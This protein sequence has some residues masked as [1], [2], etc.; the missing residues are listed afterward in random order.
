MEQANDKQDS[1]KYSHDKISPEKRR[2][3]GPSEPASIKKSFSFKTMLADCHGRRTDPI[4]PTGSHPYPIALPFLTWL[5]KPSLQYPATT[6]Y[7]THQPRS[8]AKS[9]L[10]ESNHRQ[11]YQTAHQLPDVSTPKSCCFVAP[12]PRQHYTHRSRR[13]HAAAAFLRTN[14]TDKSSLAITTDRCR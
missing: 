12:I 11:Q 8:P 10:H 1:A 9:S 6:H 13:K 2:F 5:S 7:N 3:S 4:V 14:P